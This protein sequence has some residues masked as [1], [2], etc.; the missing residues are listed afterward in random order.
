MTSKDIKLLAG[1]I[2]LESKYSDSAKKQ[3]L[4]FIANEATD[5]QIKTLILDGN[6]ET[7]AE[8]AKTIVDKRFDL[9][10]ESIVSEVVEDTVAFLSIGRD[11]ICEFVE[12]QG[13]EGDQLKEMKN[14]IMNEASDYQ[15]LSVLTDDILPD[16][17]S[18]PVA[19]TMLFEGLNM[20]TGTNFV[21]LSEY[22]ISSILNEQGGHT[23][24]NPR[25]IAIYKKID[26]TMDELKRWTGKSVKGPK[27]A[28]HVKDLRDELNYLKGE[29]GK[30][31]GAVAHATGAV[32]PAAMAAKVGDAHKTQRMGVGDIA[33]A[34]YEKGK[35]LAGKA[36]AKG[37]EVAGA[38]KEKISGALKDLPSASVIGGKISAAATSPTGMA[39]GGLAAAA[40]LGYGAYKIYKNYFSAAAKKCAGSPDKS[41]CMKAARSGAVKAQIA[42]LSKGASAC[43]KAKD[44]AKCKAAIQNKIAKLRSKMA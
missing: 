20:A 38:A 32:T 31:R 24:M 29:A 7:I 28:E 43:S 3:L 39:I 33:K 16:E 15:I 8:D 10:S 42:D 14:F 23:P 21:A 11:T 22:G 17:A 9:V 2:V 27:A 4:N 12:S 36:V 18:N 5:H 37:K 41:A 26:S 34:G 44:P 6:I 1:N 19:E 35:E 40:L 30:V 25:L 13:Y